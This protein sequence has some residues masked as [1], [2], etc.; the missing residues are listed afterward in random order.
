M[1]MS[2][3]EVAEATGATIRQVQGW[4]RRGIRGM[5]LRAAWSPITAGWE[6]Q[7]QD[8]ADFLKFASDRSEEAQRE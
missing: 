6:I 8:L 2:T 4:I 5:Q 1:I 3:K 7:E